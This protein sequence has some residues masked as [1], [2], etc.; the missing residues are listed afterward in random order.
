M[1][2]GVVHHLKAV[3]DSPQ[4]FVGNAELSDSRPRHQL[5]SLEPRKDSE[6]G[7]LL[8][9]RFRPAANQLLRLDDELDLADAARTQL[10][11][12]LQLTPLDFAGDHRLHRA[13]ALEY[14]EV[15]VTSKD[16]RPDDAVVQ[17]AVSAGSRDGARL[18]PGI[19]LPVASMLLQ[20]GLECAKTGDQRTRL[21]E[22]PEAHVHAKHETFR[23]LCVEEPYERLPEPR[24]VVLVRDLASAIGL[25]GFRI[26]KDEV[27]VR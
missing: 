6:Q 4:E 22:G 16:E 19:A 5:G 12:V 20:V 14:A 25:A 15:E 27:D 10:D 23:R 24:E 18:D 8:E 2:L 21:P 9:P 1:R 3:L 11:V 26:E 13:K 7:W 17:F